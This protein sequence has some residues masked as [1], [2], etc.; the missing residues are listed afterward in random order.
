MLTLS[1]PFGVHDRQLQITFQVGLSVY[2]LMMSMVFMVSLSLVL[3]IS[4]V[5]STRHYAQV[6]SQTFSNFFLVEM[7]GIEPASARLG[8]AVLP[9][10]EPKSSPH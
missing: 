1:Q 10:V 6:N 7:A 9:N 3:L 8:H 4:I 2:V 5:Y